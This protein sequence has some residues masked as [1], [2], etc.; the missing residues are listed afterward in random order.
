MS[1][2]HQLVS[3]Y[4][5][6]FAEDPSVQ[7]KVECLTSVRGVVGNPVLLQSMILVFL[8]QGIGLIDVHTGQKV[9]SFAVRTWQFSPHS[10][11][12]DTRVPYAVRCSRSCSVPR[13]SNRLPMTSVAPSRTSCSK[14][15][16]VR[17]C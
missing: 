16:R 4:R 10:D 15:C 12:V 2:R 6:L 9:C 1:I 11:L 7:C 8:R 13:Y 17:F 5:L 14:K 3:I